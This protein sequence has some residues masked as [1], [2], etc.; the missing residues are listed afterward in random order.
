[1]EDCSSRLS[2]LFIL[3]MDNVLSIF[4]CVNVIYRHNVMV[5]HL[6]HLTLT[7]LGV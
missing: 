5:L 7:I 2:I 1:M 3:F 4:V 6:H